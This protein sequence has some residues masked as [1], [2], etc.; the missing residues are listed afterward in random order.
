[1]ELVQAIH[2]QKH[3]LH[4][5]EFSKYHSA[6]EIR[7]CTS[8]QCT[9]PFGQRIHF[10]SANPAAVKSI[11]RQLAWQC[12]PSMQ[13]HAD[14]AMTW[15]PCRCVDRLQIKPDTRARHVS[16]LTRV[17]VSCN[18]AWHVATHIFP[19]I[20]CTE[21]RATGSRVFLQGPLHLHNCSAQAIH[22]QQQWFKH[23]TM[24]R[25]ALYSEL[26]TI[27]YLAGDPKSMYWTALW[28]AIACR[29]LASARLYSFASK[30]LWA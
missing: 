7:I 28:T 15:Q 14:V 3:T 26:S 18:C 17:A 13:G 23:L 4:L 25:L 12:D 9:L 22:R 30:G 8:K 27:A 24:P 20:L 29:V 10:S 5:N 2:L 21:D 16:C 1:M 6:V 11:C 19:V